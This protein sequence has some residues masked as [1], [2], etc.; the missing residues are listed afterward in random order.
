MVAVFMG[1]GDADHLVQRKLHRI[2]PP[3]NFLRAEPD[4]DEQHGALVLQGEGI[5]LGS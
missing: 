3:A 5:A 1:E 4:I 2:G